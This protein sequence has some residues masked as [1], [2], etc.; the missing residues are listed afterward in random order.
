M[1]KYTLTN[2]SNGPKVVNSTPPVTL[3]VGET[4]ADLEINDDEALSQ[5][6]TGWFDGFDGTKGLSGY[7]KAELTDIALLEGVEIAPTANK[8]EIVAAIEAKRA[9]NN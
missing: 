3:Q 4:R 6:G 5:G 1:A 8:A 9:E 2:I 7:N